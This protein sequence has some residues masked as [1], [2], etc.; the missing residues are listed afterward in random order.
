MWERVNENNDETTQTV[1]HR[2]RLL[3]GT[4]AGEGMKKVDIAQV[5]KQA[6]V[7]TTTVSRVLNEVATVSEDNRRRVLDAIRQLKYHPNPNAQHLASGKTDTAGIIIPRFEGVFHSYYALQVIKGIGIAA[8]RNRYNL[9]LH[10]SNGT[11][12]VN[13]ASVAGLLFVDITGCEEL[14]DR[15]LDEQVPIVVLNHYIEELPVSCVAVDNRLAAQHVVDYLTRLGH[16]DIAIITG[17]LKTQSGLDRL[18]GFLKALKSHQLPVHD[19]YIR[20]GDYGLPSARAAAEA[21]LS[22][23]NRPTA[24]FACSDEMAVE[25]INIALAKGVRVPEELS[26]VGF[27]DNPIAEHGRVPLTTVRQPLSDMGRQGLELLIQ[28]AKGKRS[29]P[30]KLLM[31]TELVERQSCRQTWLER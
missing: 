28:Q 18:D 19:D 5:A 24:I 11:S 2:P 9:L 31:P 6:R 25:A 1:L 4:A 21:L 7:S 16:K 8:E 26:V 23:P 15:A 27:D 17:D 14:L 10:V 30:T 12:L 22:L 3:A 20:H 13:L 29:S